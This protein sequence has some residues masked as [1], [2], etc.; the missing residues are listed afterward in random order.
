MADL[1][2][3]FSHCFFLGNLLYFLYF[4]VDCPI[5][6][7]VLKEEF[8]MVPVFLVFIISFYFLS[9]VYMLRGF[10]RLKSKSLK[11]VICHGKI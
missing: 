6:V 4:D 3:L 8:V 2:M 1:L 10:K 9:E 11:S 7:S 5:C